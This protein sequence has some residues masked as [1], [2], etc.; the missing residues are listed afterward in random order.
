MPRQTSAQHAAPY[1]KKFAAIA[2]KVRELGGTVRDV[3]EALLVPQNALQD[4]RATHPAFAQALL[5]ETSRERQVAQAYFRRAIGYDYDAEKLINC[6][7]RLKPV[8]YRVH[9]PPDVKAAQIVLMNFRP[10]KWRLPG[11][12]EPVPE[13]NGMLMA[14]YRA[15]KER[16]TQRQKS[17]KPHPATGAYPEQY[18]A[19]A[20]K[21]YAL[22]GTTRDV[23]EALDVPKSTIENR[24]LTHEAFD[25]ACRQ[26][27]DAAEKQLN[28]QLDLV[29]QALYRRATGYTY[30]AEKVSSHRGRVTRGRDLKHVPP[31]AQAAQFVLFNR[32]SDQWQ[33]PDKI[34]FASYMQHVRDAVC[35]S[36]DN[37]GKRPKED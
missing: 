6:K 36:L 23:A 11:K 34:D 16:L 20:G 3:A 17:E 30:M 25:E 9:V 5:T 33:P 31:D 1:Q 37:T 32:S 8:K 15:A 19:A 22:G 21:I 2:R 27:T 10:E 7:G 26:G 13:E 35:R 18:A 14:L 28:H 24:R 12:V 4:W 29:E